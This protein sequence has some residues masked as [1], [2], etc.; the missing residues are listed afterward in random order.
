VRRMRR[1]IAAAQVQPLVVATSRA[2]EQP[3]RAGVPRDA[4]VRRER[5]L[6]E[7]LVGR[8]SG[9]PRRKYR[10]QYLLTVLRVDAIGVDPE[11]RFD[12]D[13]AAWLPAILEVEPE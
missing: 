4:E 3:P 12:R 8:D 1:A 9:E 10:A 11:P 7:F 2:P 6:R 5:C 13:V